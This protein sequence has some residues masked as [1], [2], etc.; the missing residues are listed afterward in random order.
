M[1]QNR[2]NHGRAKSSQARTADSDP[3][4]QSPYKLV[5]NEPSQLNTRWSLLGLKNETLSERWTTASEPG[6]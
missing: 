5:V 1:R 2:K 3:L 6:S 4:R